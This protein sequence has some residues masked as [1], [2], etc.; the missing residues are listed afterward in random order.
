[1]AKQNYIEIL[2]QAIALLEENT[3]D[4]NEFQRGYRKGKTEAY[5]NIIKDLQKLE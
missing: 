5:K 1:M 2:K 3:E 4:L